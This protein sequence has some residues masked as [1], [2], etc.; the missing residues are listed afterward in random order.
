MP[1]I[2]AH[3]NGDASEEEQ[4]PQAAPEQTPLQYGLHIVVMQKSPAARGFVSRCDIVPREYNAKGP[5]PESAEQCVR[6]CTHCHTESS[7]PGIAGN[8]VA[9]RL[10]S[11]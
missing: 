8:P 3:P 2:T 7:P 4:R 6:H 11:V 9:L 1:I 5:R 10:P